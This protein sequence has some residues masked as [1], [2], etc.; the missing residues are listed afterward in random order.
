MDEKTKPI[1]EPTP[2]AGTI[3]VEL[4]P[5]SSL[6]QLAQE[7][8]RNFDAETDARR[9][10]RNKR[11]TEVRQDNPRKAA[12]LKKKVQLRRQKRKTLRALS[13]KNAA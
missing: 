3:E 13:R 11:K 10:A 4:G 2:V 12:E 6:E 9:R 5:Q 7:V 1:D 8:Q